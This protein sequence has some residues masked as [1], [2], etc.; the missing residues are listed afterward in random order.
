MTADEQK[1][2]IEAALQWAQIVAAEATWTH[3]P[4]ETDDLLTDTELRTCDLMRS[5]R[6]LAE[7]R[8]RRMLTTY[9]GDKIESQKRHNRLERELSELLD[10]IRSRDV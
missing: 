10:G 6:V 5:A 2:V 3:A 8:Y 4:R 1:P 9:V 7:E